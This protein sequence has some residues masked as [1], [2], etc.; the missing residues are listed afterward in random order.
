MIDIITIEDLRRIADTTGEWCTSIFL[1]THRA[2]PEAQQD[3]IRLK[4]LLTRAE[5]EIVALGLRSTEAKRALAPAEA[6]LDEPG[7]WADQES[8]L[9]I[10]LLDGSL[11]TFRLVDPVDELVVVADRFHLKPLLSARTG[12]TYHV[13]ALSQHRTRLLRGN[14]VQLAEIGLGEAPT[15]IGEALQWDDRERQVQS[16]GADRVGQGRVTATFHGHGGAKDTSKD[17]LA[18]YL[19]T[20][21]EAIGQLVTDRNSPLVLAGVDEV[22]AAYRQ[23]SERRRIVG[24]SVAGNVDRLGPDELHRRAWPL[25]EPVFDEDRLAAIDRFVD[26]AAPTGSSASDVVTRARAG[27]VETLFVPTDAHLWGTLGPDGTT[28]V[29]HETKQA[30]DRDLYDL[31]AIETLTHDGAVFAMARD[32]IPGDGPLAALF[33]F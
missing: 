9:A 13:L 21:D 17:D 30:G 25:V 24:P 32:A 19:R 31:A 33:R 5:D 11:T 22:V 14:A 28:V 1:P 10:Y 12:A 7:F 18:R 29:E 8:G 6:L 27:Q 23:T 2:G 4:N 16:H 26:R 3:P 15:S 20:I